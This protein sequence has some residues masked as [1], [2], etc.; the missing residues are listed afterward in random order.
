MS[1]VLTFRPHETVKFYEKWDEGIPSNLYAVSLIPTPDPLTPKH[2]EV[3][4][5]AVI[6]MGY[7]ECVES[8][9]PNEQL[10]G[11]MSIP[12]ADDRDLIADTLIESGA[13]VGEWY[14]IEVVPG[15]PR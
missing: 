3:N 6:C 1:T 9:Q 10:W 12:D 4:P 13:Q 8:Q 14:F 7:Y 11:W 5:F 15:E 2:P